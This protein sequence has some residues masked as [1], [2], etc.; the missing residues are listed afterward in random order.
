M[1]IFFL[2]IEITLEEITGRDPEGMSQARRHEDIAVRCLFIAESLFWITGQ[3]G[4]WGEHDGWIY[5]ESSFHEALQR[6]GTL[7]EALAGAASE[8]VQKLAHLQDRS[9]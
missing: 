8:E 2:P 7:G 1:M 9:E 4:H 6:I 5:K 3:L